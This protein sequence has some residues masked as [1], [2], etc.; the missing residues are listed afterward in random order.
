MS[1]A[2]APTVEAPPADEPPVQENTE[3]TP[4]QTEQ[5]TE[6][7]L[8]T[9]EIPQTTQVTPPIENGP[10]TEEVMAA[11]VTMEQPT[12]ADSTEVSKEPNEKLENATKTQLQ[13]AVVLTIDTSE[14]EG[15]MT[16]IGS[17]AGDP[18]LAGYPPDCGTKNYKYLSFAK[19]RRD[20][21]LTHPMCYSQTLVDK[22]NN[23]VPMT[24]PVCSTD[25]GAHSFHKLPTDS[26]VLSK[27]GLGMSL[28]FK[29]LKVMAW[30]FLIMLVLS[31]PAMFVFIICG[32][33][34]TEQVKLKLQ[35]N[36]I[37]VLGMTSMGNLG[38]ESTTCAQAQ[39][40][41]PLT[42]TCDYGEIGS[43]MAAY[44]D[45]ATQGTCSCPTAYQVNGQ[46]NCQS[47]LITLANGT[48]TCPA[49]GN[50]CFPGNYP[51]SGNPCCSYQ[52]TSSG[53][54]DFSALEVQSTPGCSAPLAQSILNG[55]C[56]GEAS[57]TLNV[58]E[59]DI[60]RWKYD[61]TWNTTCPNANSSLFCQA[62]LTDQ[63]DFASCP[64]SSSRG[65]IAIAKC[66]T[67]QIDI[68]KTWAFRIMGW[69]YV[70]R[71]HF[72]EM[73]IALD[74][75]SCIVFLLIV[76]WMKKQEKNA[77]ARIELERTTV[78]NYTVQLMHLP[79]HK[80]VPLLG[81]ELKKHLES[82]LSSKP[83]VY[84]A[85]ITEVKVADI[86]FGMTN[87]AQIDA[88]RKRGT[89][90]SK[91]FLV[92][93][94]ITKFKALQEK[95]KP[96]VFEKRLAK[97]LKESRKLDDELKK[98]DDWLDDWEKVNK[99]NRLAA[100]TAFITFEEEEGYL[101]CLREY[102]NLGF[103]HRLFQP[104]HK[105]FLKKRM[106]IEPAPDPTDIIWENLDYTWFNRT[107]RI[108]GV[109]LVAISLL[110]LSFL[111][112][113]L[114]KTKK[115]ELT[116]QFGASV[117]C[118]ANVTKLDVIKE[119][120][121][122]PSVQNMVMCYCKDALLTA[123]LTQAMNT[124]FIDPA[125]GKSYEYCKTWGSQYLTIQALMVGSVLVVIVVNCFLTPTLQ[126]LVHLQKS[127]TL[128]EVIVAIVSKI[129]IAQF[130]N[131]ALI[132]IFLNANLSGVSSY[133]ATGYSIATLSL[134]NGKYADFSIDWYNDVG[135]SLMLT[136]FINVVSPQI[137]VFVTY[138][139]LEIRRWIDRGCSFDYSY[140]RQE[141]Q[142]DLEALYRGPEF[143][144]A[145]RYA[146]II[147]T[148]FITLMV[149]IFSSGMPLMLFIGLVSVIVVYWTDK[150]TFLRVVR[151][152]PQYDGRIA[153]VVGSM[154]P[155]A[156]FLHALIG[157]WMYSNT[158]IFQ[159]SSAVFTVKGY[160][161][162]SVLEKGGKLVTRA[163]MMP[164]AVLFGVLVL[165]VAV[166]LIRL[167]VFNYFASVLR[168]VFPM[169]I[170]MFKQPKPP[171]NLPSY[172]DALPRHVLTEGLA[173][174]TLKPELV[175]AYR[176]T[177]ARRPAPME[178]SSGDTVKPGVGTK[179]TTLQLD[180]CHTYDILHNP[181]YKEAFGGGAFSRQLL[182]P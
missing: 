48:Q 73:A 35:K 100:V 145:T 182:S 178:G 115:N 1:E 41:K 71:E 66:Y 101:R 18:Q 97:L 89:V 24:Y 151:S 80:D 130:F 12:A 111:I 17:P 82:V 3:G 61:S 107:C 31:I 102:P 138:V 119:Q 141:T 77:I 91:L 135:V 34:N 166:V 117:T 153:S 180:G 7:N 70:T 10:P 64:N 79:K 116:A 58:S 55:L 54:A 56:L 76:L 168:S 148:I 114:A 63:A 49:S 104:Y 160:N 53:Q 146:Q 83:P 103:F 162:N 67:T 108:V 86:N 155:Y 136:M 93:Q 157:I 134:L 105:R 167:I 11:E 85:N 150:F 22:M 20:R 127:H 120:L 152:P 59:T 142:R 46:G 57:C 175:E 179:V 4:P 112:I 88:M 159:T 9:E 62:G 133:P 36:P 156:M 27:Y 2:Q 118:P 52:K 81:N 94:R 14:P 149:S 8:S 78:Q 177:L 128:S 171:R 19:C 30:V 90:A 172:F 139:I 21:G 33:G 23:P 45:Y 43:I 113:Y 121:L 65:L 154:L 13:D 32:S 132:V 69:D 165:I 92:T 98:Y 110:L 5:T 75:I 68:S 40:G 50:G 15:F 16:T 169:C 125:T 29:F 137:G 44:S 181:T 37:A 129:F 140:T 161:L 164:T 39:F 38:E 122:T 106:K 95:L 163:T 84:N 158:N 25:F 72:L 124:Q 174:K 131:T 176:A 47:S 123:S 87:A 51:S 6:A 147:N 99:G 42:L 60:Y 143:D 109:N 144:L 74:I 96:T 28:Y 126:Y 26:Q 173:S 170:R